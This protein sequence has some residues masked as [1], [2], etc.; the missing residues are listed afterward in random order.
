MFWKKMLSQAF[1]PLANMPKTRVVYRVFALL[2]DK[3]H[4]DL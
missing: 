2:Y 1:M 4:Q 3:L